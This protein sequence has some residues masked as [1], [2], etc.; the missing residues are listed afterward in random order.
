V[1]SSQIFNKNELFDLFQNFELYCILCS[2]CCDISSG[3]M[4]RH[5]LHYFCISCMAEYLTQSTSKE[6]K[7]PCCDNF[8]EVNQV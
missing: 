5:C 1:N 2:S 6:I 8:I 3:I 4:M 7:C